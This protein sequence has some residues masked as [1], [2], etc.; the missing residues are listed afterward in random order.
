MDARMD[1]YP[2]SCTFGYCVRRRPDSP[3]EMGV[4]IPPGRVEN[5]KEI[6][7][8]GG[9]M[10]EYERRIAELEQLLGKKEVGIALLKNF[11]GP[12]V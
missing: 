10:T 6:F 7:T 2:R 11:L 4:P 3:R 8:R 9:V 1:I 12:N 5:G